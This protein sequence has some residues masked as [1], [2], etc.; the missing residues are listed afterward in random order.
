ME[1]NIEQNQETYLGRNDTH[2]FYSTGLKPVGERR[3]VK[4]VHARTGEISYKVEL[5]NKT[6]KTLNRLAKYADRLRDVYEV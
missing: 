2:M 1:V 5:F 3:C 6:Y 4:L